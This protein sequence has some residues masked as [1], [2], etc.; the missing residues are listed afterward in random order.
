MS[1]RGTPGS[2][3]GDRVARATALIRAL[4]GVVDA[5]VEM[6]GS[7]IRTVAVVVEPALSAWE[8]TR[9]VQSALL[10]SLGLAIDTAIVEV[11]RPPADRG[12]PEDAPEP[13]GEPDP[14][15]KP[16]RGNGAAAANGRARAN[17]VG[18]AAANGNGKAP[19]SGSGKPPAN[20]SGKSLWAEHANG[21]S[22]GAASG[23]DVLPPLDATPAGAPARKRTGAT[24]A[25]L[26][27]ETRGLGRIGCR[28]VVATSD[29]IAAG[30]SEGV[31]TPVGRLEAVA[32]AVVAASRIPGADLD[33]IRLVE[34]AG[35]KYVI[36]AVRAWSGRDPAYRAE[37]AAADASPEAA[38]AD[39]TLGALVQ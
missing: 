27:L 16:P 38:A 10:A 7:G 17:G 28:V 32:R 29:R 39:A 5:R 25:R 21:K 8:I 11:T 26:E 14:V 1:A 4:K 22:K 6:D 33:A 34:L 35:R 24:V 3:Q 9:N 18:K 19:A 31:D 2:S 20:G 36:V 15:A 37:V 13:A 30:E 12:A 23:A